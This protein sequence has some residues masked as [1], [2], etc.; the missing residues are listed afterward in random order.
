MADW[1]AD[2]ELS[3]F[4]LHDWPRRT[5][6]LRL[7]STPPQVGDFVYLFAHLVGTDKPALHR[8]R[9]LEISPRS[10]IY[11]P[12]NPTIELGGTSGAP[13]LNEQGK[14]VGINAGGG[15]FDD[16]MHA[17]ANPLNA[18]LPKLREAMSTQ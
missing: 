16:G 17:C 1:A 8:G 12:D 3:V 2:G 13:V 11:V 14:V 9:V 4:V 5:K 15:K 7:A 10:L 6:F 18:F